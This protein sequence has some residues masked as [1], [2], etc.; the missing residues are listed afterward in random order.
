LPLAQVEMIGELK[1]ILDSDAKTN[2]EAGPRQPARTAKRKAVTRSA[3]PRP[4]PILLTD[5][6]EP[7]HAVTGRLSER[8]VAVNGAAA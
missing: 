4:R 1:N 6:V 3:K 8:H 5:I 2:P 7:A